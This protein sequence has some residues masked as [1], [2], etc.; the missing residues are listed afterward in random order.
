MIIDCFT[1]FNEYDILEGRLE[2]LHDTVDYF[3][4]VEANITHSGKPKSFNYQDSADRYKKYSDKIIYST[5]EIDSTKYNWNIRSTRTESYSPQWAVENA[6]RNHIAQALKQFGP[7]DVVMISDVDEIPNKQMIGEV[8]RHLT[9]EMPAIAMIQDM[10]YYNLN[11]KQVAPW[12]GT[13]VTSN[14]LVQQRRPQWFRSKRNT[15]PGAAN[16][17]WHLSYWGGVDNI[18]TKL[19]SFAHQEHNTDEIKDSI[20]RRMAAGEDLFGRK[21]NLFIPTDRHTL[22]QDFLAIFD[23]TPALGIPHYYETVEG[24]FRSDDIAFYKKIINYFSGPAHFVEIGSYKGRSASFMAVE[25]ANSGK[26]IQFDCVD[27]WQGSEEHQAGQE[28]EDQDVVNNRLFDVFLNNI[29]PVKEYITPVRMTSLDAAATYADASL[30]FVFIDAAHDYD[31]VRADILVWNPKVKEGGII[32]GHDY[33]HPPLK[34]AV[35]EIFGELPSIG[36][37]WYKIK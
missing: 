11:Q 14:Q 2:Y 30:D 19:E 22:P 23:H 8:V 28:S 9:P 21:D 27:T 5:I 7:D 24:F 34:K 3:V 20:E 12:A 1:F 16:G 33:P 29:A 37:C 32:S 17:G 35:D 18:R 25:I 6:Q 10:F 31:S 13:V 36:A 4:I 26:P 15:L